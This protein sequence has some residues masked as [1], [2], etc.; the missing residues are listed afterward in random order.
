MQMK[1]HAVRGRQGVTHL[2]L[3]QVLQDL[4]RCQATLRE[5]AKEAACTISCKS[6]ML[7]MQNG[8]LHNSPQALG[9]LEQDV[10]RGS[11]AVGKDHQRHER[12]AG[13][14][15]RCACAGLSCCA[16]AAAAAA[17]LGDGRGARFL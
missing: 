6:S 14:R 12:R 13:S 11:G 4:C 10:R 9:V 2:E 1:M 5:V 8:A 15:R 17:W 7:N 16:I 3:E